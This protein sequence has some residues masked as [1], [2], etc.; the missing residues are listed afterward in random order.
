MEMGFSGKGLQKSGKGKLMKPMSI[1]TSD[2]FKVMLHCHDISVRIITNLSQS[3][4]YG[5]MGD[6]LAPACS[7]PFIC[8][9]V[10]TLNQSNP[11]QIRLS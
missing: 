2:L 1:I 10:I 8:G 7:F 4:Y 9:M 3:P 11:N 6:I 5:R